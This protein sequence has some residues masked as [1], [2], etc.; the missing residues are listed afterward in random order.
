MNKKLR[1][2]VKETVSPFELF[3][4]SPIVSRVLQNAISRLPKKDV[5]DDE[6]RCP[7]T[8]SGV[9]ANLESLFVRHFHQ[10]QDSLLLPQSFTELTERCEKGVLRIVDIGSGAGTASTAAMDI[11]ANVL[12]TSGPRFDRP[13]VVDIVL[14]DISNVAMQEGTKLIRAFARNMR[15]LGVRNVV[16]VSGPFPKSTPQ[17]QRIQRNVGLYDFCFMSYA[18]A[19]IKED[20]QYSEIADGLDSMIRA[21]DGRTCGIVLQDKFH[22]SMARQLTA[23][24]GTSCKKVT[25][26]Q[27]VHD[28]SN[29]NDAQSYTFFRS[30]LGSPVSATAW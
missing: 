23:K 8:R 25:I 26:R 27:K 3:A 11:A 5:S 22:E 6:Q 13:L 28:P 21:S 29:G 9:R 16:P 7:T 1:N 2:Q 18:L 20:S 30:V 19:A 12:E 24:L 14:N 4:L 10:M 15:R 17:L